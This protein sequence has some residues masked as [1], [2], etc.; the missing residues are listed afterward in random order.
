MTAAEL[1][2]APILLI[3][4]GD[5]GSAVG[6]QMLADGAPVLGLRRDIGRLPRGLPGLAVDYASADMQR[7]AQW[8][9]DTVVLTPMPAE[10]SEAGYRKGYVE[11]V[12][13][14]LRALEGT[15]PRRILLVSSTRVYGEQGGAWIDEASALM[16]T[17]YAGELI[18]QAE[19]L[20]L[21][22]PHQAT[23]IRFGG[24]YGRWPSRLI[25]RI[26]TGRLRRRSPTVF[27]N[28]IHRRDCVG[29]LLAL[30]GK[31]PAWRDSTALLPG[32]GQ[33]AGEPVGGRT[34]AGFTIAS[35]ASTRRSPRPGRGRQTLPEYSIAA[36]WISLAVSG[37][38]GR[39][40]STVGR[41][42]GPV[43]SLQ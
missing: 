6:L 7:L 36:Q 3:G 10:Y 11:P 38:P 27:G 15:A 34:L 12:T 19:R 16:P 20:L 43:N 13:R 24:I 29:M 41:S 17:D 4:C 33:C 23:I 8:D 18:C 9:G 14:L 28:R 22:S 1:K 35:Y 39:L 30:V 21:Q 42:R 25:Q 37:L 26:Q 2:G 40:W 31:T 32:C 5:I